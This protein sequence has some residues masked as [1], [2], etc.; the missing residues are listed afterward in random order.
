MT[1]NQSRTEEVG[2]QKKKRKPA[3]T[4]TERGN[5]KNQT[6]VSLRNVVAIKKQIMPN[7]Y[8]WLK[9]NICYSEL[10]EKKEMSNIEDFSQTLIEP[11]IYMYIQ[12]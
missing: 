3:K 2:S 9:P 12:H 10:S 5:L 7:V 1:W 11:C 6:E 8:G 4:L